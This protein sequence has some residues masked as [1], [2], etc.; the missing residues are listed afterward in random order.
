MRSDPQE[1]PVSLSIRLYR[2]LLNVYPRSFRDRFADGMEYAFKSEQR[3][4]AR[5][6]KWALIA[7]LVRSSLHA[8]LFGLAERVIGSGGNGRRSEYRGSGRAAARW[9][10]CTAQDVGYSL[11]AMRRSPVF[12]LVTVLTLALGIGASTAMFSTAHDA[13]LSPLPFVES[14]RLVMGRATFNGSLNPWASGA[15][16]LDYRDRSDAFQALGAIM[17]F[18]Q[19]HTI[20]GGEEPERVTGTVV[21]TNLFSALGVN[22]RIGRHF[23]AVE[24]TADAE[25]VVIIG[26]G[27]WQRRFGGTADVLGRTLTADAIPHTIVGVMAA[28]FSFMPDVEF[29]RPMRPDRD[30]ASDRRFHN[31]LLIGRLRSGVS[32]DQAQSQL[33]VISA[34]LASTYPETNEGKGI[35]LTELHTALAADYRTRLYLL[36]AAVALVLL[37]AC[38]N[39]IGIFLARAPVRRVELSVRAALGASRRRLVSQLIVESLVV[40]VAAGVVGTLLAVWWQQIV[41]D[42]VQLDIPG[43]GANGISGSMLSYAVSL[44]VTTGVTVGIY[45]ALC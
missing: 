38:A 20:T 32:L 36:V 13:L 31:W 12:A 45:P 11:R 41:S 8:L 10:G 1:Q 21:S 15:D 7:F 43:L 24:G 19:D 33:D 16:Y 5:A 37:I 3:E 34:R 35:L 9:I 4:A 42:Y 2:C 14:E 40:A 6:G 27:Y 26:H 39:V 25:D 22:P 29:W 17:P 30:A 18:G 28:G 44:S 23:R